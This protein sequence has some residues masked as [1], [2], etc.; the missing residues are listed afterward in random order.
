MFKNMKLSMKLVLGFG[1]VLVA[2][3]IVG[4]TGFI[5]PIVA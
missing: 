1:V 2:L 4:S 3:A 5:N